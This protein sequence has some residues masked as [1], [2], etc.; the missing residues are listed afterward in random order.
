MILTI[1]YELIVILFVGLS[2]WNLLTHK[3][4]F[5]QIAYMLVIIPFVLRMLFIR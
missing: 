3:D 4:V 2:I 1:L 5:K